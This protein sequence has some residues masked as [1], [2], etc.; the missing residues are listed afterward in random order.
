MSNN[1]NNL[2]NLN[3]ELL[4]GFYAFWVFVILNIVLWLFAPIALIITVYAAW[5]GYKLA[6]YYDHKRREDK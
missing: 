6:A 1:S 5:I 2:S 3:N 4:I